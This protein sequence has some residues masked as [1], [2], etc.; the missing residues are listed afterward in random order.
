[1]GSEAKF[2][3]E[4]Y[5]H[6]DQDCAKMESENQPLSSRWNF[7]EV[8]VPVWC[9]SRELVGSITDTIGSKLPEDVVRF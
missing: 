9:P 7:G 6:H 5:L 3:P 4:E 1:M 2:Y 8:T